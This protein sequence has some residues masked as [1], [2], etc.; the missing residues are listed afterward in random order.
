MLKPYTA[1]QNVCLQDILECRR[2][3]LIPIRNHIDFNIQFHPT[4]DWRASGFSSKH[5]N[6]LPA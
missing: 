6:P 2:Y 1:K 4:M 3:D 5:F